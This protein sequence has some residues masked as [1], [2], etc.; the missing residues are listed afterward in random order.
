MVSILIDVGHPAHVHLFRNAASAWQ[1]MGHSVHWSAL[2]REIIIDLLERY[3]L[4][5][6]ISYRRRSGKFHLLREIP[7]RT[8]KTL[9]IAQQHKTDLFV[10]ICNPIIGIVAKMMNK[11]YLATGDTELAYNQLAVTMPFVTRLLTPDVFYRDVGHKHYRY[12][13]YHEL[14][15]LHPDVYTP[16]DAIYDAIGLSKG[17][18]FSIVR[19]IAWNATHD[20]HEKG[21]AL[22]DKERI[23]HILRQYGK[24]IVSSESELPLHLK[25][26]VITDY[27]LDKMSDLLAFAQIYVG[28]GNTMASEAAVL[29]TPSIRVNT[30]DLGYCRDLQKR[31]LMFQVL[32]GQDIIDT[33]QDILESPSRESTFTHRRQEMLND[34]CNTTKVIV[35]QANTLLKR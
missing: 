12:A 7:I 20:A 14:A 4:L 23:I 21:F 16:D 30:M 9:A 19:F 22:Q 2:D 35:E 33:I 15:Y 3:G 31:Q 5:Y 8:W 27:P 34:K 6:S 24:V 1:S 32:S 28:E 18:P 29:G 10:S 25:K 26:D 13:G 17:T 11:P